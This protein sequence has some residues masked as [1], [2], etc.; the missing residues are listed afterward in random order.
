MCLWTGSPSRRTK[1]KPYG[2]KPMAKSLNFP[3]ASMFLSKKASE[4]RSSSLLDAGQLL[5]CTLIR[6]HITSSGRKF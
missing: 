4:Q 2:K 6:A 5:L 1:L 3:P